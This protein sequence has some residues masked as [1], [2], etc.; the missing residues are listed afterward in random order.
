MHCGVVST[1]T[2]AVCRETENQT[3]YSKYTLACMVY[4]NAYYI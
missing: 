3:V 1:C 2:S 4:A